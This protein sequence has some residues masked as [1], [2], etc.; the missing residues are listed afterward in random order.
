MIDIEAHAPHYMMANTIITQGFLGYINGVIGT[1]DASMHE[2]A[3]VRVLASCARVIQTPC[4]V[5]GAQKLPYMA[6]PTAKSA[7]L[8]MAIFHS[9]SEVPTIIPVLGIRE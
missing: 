9:P 2:L 1:T 8:L 4:V 3:A 5:P 6:G 7:V